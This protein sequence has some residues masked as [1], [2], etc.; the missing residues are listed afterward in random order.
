MN[1]AK[2]NVT[3]TTQRG[4]NTCLTP[5]LSRRF[6]TNERMLMYDRLPHALFSDTFIAG[7]VSKRGNK[8]AQIYGASFGW[9]R[10]FHMAKKGDTHETLYLLFKWDGVPPKMIVY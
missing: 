5:S 6:L 2:Q 7:S 4:L 8:Y 10:A 9:A 3:K 1:C